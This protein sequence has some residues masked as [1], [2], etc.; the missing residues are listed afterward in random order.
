MLQIKDFPTNIEIRGEVYIKKV[1]FENLK[2]NLQILEM[3]HQVL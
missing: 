1:D 3:Q 2:E